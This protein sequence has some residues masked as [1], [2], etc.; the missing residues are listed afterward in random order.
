MKI[1]NPESVGFSS[2]R[3]ARIGTVMQRYVDQGSLAG[4]VTLIARKG[5]VAHFEKFGMAEIETKKPMT[6]DTIF[7]IYSMTKPITSVAVLM[8]YEE[9]RLRLADPVSLYIPAFKH[10]KVLDPTP[11]LGVRTVDAAREITIHDLLTHTAGLSYGFDREAYLDQLIGKNIWQKMEKNPEMTLEDWV[12]EIAKLPLAFHPG[13]TFQYSMATDVLGYLVQVVSGM[14]FAEF[15]QKRIFE[16]LGMV[17]T[18]FW[19]PPE[20]VARFAASYSSD[21]KNGLK[22]ADAAAT[23]PYT[24]PTTHPSGGGGLVSTAADYLRFCQMLLNGGALDGV[25]LLGRKTIELMT[26]NHLP[27]GVHPWGNQE[28]GF[29]YGVS[30]LLDLGKTKLLNSVGNYGWSGAANTHF[31]IDPQ[32]DLIAILMLQCIPDNT[33]PITPDFRTLTYQALI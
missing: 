29:G 26:V 5:Q 28:S 30:V 8:L 20:K 10:M 2:E 12:M 19:V 23:S 9:A 15:L 21:P 22:L 7:R 31:W 17:D 32:E 16:P 4:M 1:V 25:R 27:D 6:L 18:G 11:G 24:R 14:P 3:L 33:Y 13:T